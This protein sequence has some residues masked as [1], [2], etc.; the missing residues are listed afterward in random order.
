MKQ[1]RMLDELTRYRTLDRLGEGAM[2]EVWRVEDTLNPS[3]PLALKRTKL[4]AGDA[5]ELTLRFQAEFHAM[6][7]LSH[8]N[9]VGVHDYGV[10]SAGEVYLVMDWVP[11]QDL[12]A[13]VTS[14]PLPLERFY[15]LFAQLLQALD[16]LH[17]RQLVH[18]DIKADNVRIRPDD[19]LVLMDFGLATPPGDAEDVPI[20]GT[21]GY[22]APEILLGRG[23]SIRTD[24]YAVGCLVYEMLTGSLPFQ[25]PV[26]QVLRAHLQER[27]PSLAAARP[28]AP[29]SLVSLVARLLEKDPAQR[30]QTAAQVLNELAGMAGLALTR[31]SLAQRQSFLSAPELVGRAADMNAL[32]EALDDAA[33][34]RGRGVLVAAPA[35]TGKS[36]LLQE[37]TL[38]AQLAGFSVLHGRCR[39]QGATSY[40]A[41]R[42]GLR[43]GL[44]SVASEF[45]DRHRTTL[46]ALY[47]ERRSGPVTGEQ[48]VSIDG[49]VA[50]LQ[51]LAAQRPVLWILDDLHWADPQTVAI[52]NAAIRALADSRLLC[53]GTFRDDETPAGNLVW[54]TAEE[55]A[56]QLLRLKPLSRPEQD[57]LLAALLPGANIPDGFAEALFQATGGNPL[58]IQEALRVLLEESLLRREGGRWF[59]P[60]DPS[61][62]QELQ[63]VEITIQRRLTHLAP[64]TLAVLQVAAVL[65]AHMSLQVLV[66]CAAL[67]EAELFAALTDLLER[68]LLERDAAGA[69]TFPHDRVREV[70]YASIEV[71]RRATLHLRAA[72][73]LVA[74]ASD[75][76]DVNPAD[77]AR[78]FL[79]GGDDERGAAWALRAAEHAVTAGADFVALEHW[80][81][82]DEALERLPGDQLEQRFPIWLRMGRDGFHLAAKRATQALVRAVAAW[83]AEPARVEAWLAQRGLDAA[84]LLVLCGRA[85]GMMG[86]IKDALALSDRLDGLLKDET[87][88][89][90]TLAHSCRYLALLNAGH[91]DELMRR[92]ERAVADIERVPP[93]ELPAT[94]G[95]FLVGTYSFLNA[96]GLQGTRPETAILDKALAA[97]AAV[98]DP[99][100]FWPRV[101]FGLW[102]LWA[103][104]FDETEAYI[105]RTVRRTRAI[106]APPSPFVLYLRP[107]LQFYRGEYAEALASLERSLESHAHLQ[108]QAL[109]FFLCQV[110]RGRLL[111]AVDRQAE[112]LALFDNLVSTARDKGLG[113]TLIQA[114]MGRGSVLR[115]QGEGPAAREAY[116]EAVA[117]AAQ[118]TLRNPLLQGHA[119]MGLG[120]CELANDPR[121]AL[122]YLDEALAIVQCPELDNLLLPAHAER[123]RARALDALGRREEAKQARQKARRLFQKMNLPY[124]IYQVEQD[125]S[126]AVPVVA[127]AIPQNPPSADALQARFERFGRLM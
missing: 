65:G 56:S 45:N 38:R 80:I 103:G 30:P 99:D 46:E 96:R 105:D 126:A 12:S 48:P 34:G 109:P 29:P 74:R 50:L 36:R 97:A 110:L 122:T 32:G 61:V 60:E 25:G 16:Y 52:L 21:P 98:G 106:G 24:L 14:G 72:E 124:W 35:G 86:E 33:A 120:L 40:E 78:H 68:Q 111:D 107:A 119:T 28:D 11:G 71:H 87:G 13:L 59:F 15:A 101:Y 66:A 112:A 116:R 115:D 102:S 43:P 2:G 69:L 117:L 77:L 1:H 100:P 123:A 41:L 26:R 85:L 51:D 108:E 82:A 17:T 57:E 121:L 5:A 89:R 19:V 53:I 55:G 47:A 54:Q 39:E 91:I 95:R 84:E 44:A 90:R 76:P 92:S 73:F 3:L 7:R 23:A 79:R 127:A 62:L 9:I 58:F 67:P 94:V 42:E 6:A 18:R 49:V 22:M 81:A 118:G 10:K 114:L 4:Q 31:E 75:G 83:E 88:L 70:A 64:Q 113:L 104:H 37:L 27:V 8:P 93:A 125:A 63:K 20:S